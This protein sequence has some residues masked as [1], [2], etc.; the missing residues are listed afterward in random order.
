MLSHHTGTVKV[1]KQSKHISVEKGIQ[2]QKSA[3]T[4][5]LA[6]VQKRSITGSMLGLISQILV[7]TVFM[8]PFN[9]IFWYIMQFESF[10]GRT[11]L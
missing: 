1:N 11:K 6:R 10:L 4:A 5:V 2:S 9:C 3:C 7:K 8:W